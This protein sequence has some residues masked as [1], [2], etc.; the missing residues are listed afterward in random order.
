MTEG[1]IRS[2]FL[3]L[4][5]SMTTQAQA[6]NTQVKASTLASRLRDFTRMNSHMFFGSKVDKHP[7]DFL[8]EVYTIL[9]AMGRVLV[10]RKS[11][12]AINSEM[13]PKLCSHNGSIIG[14]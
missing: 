7:L 9:F 3:S 11:M 5:Q 8:D 12:L 10:R 6:V 14:L 13:Y 4:S 2:D 1:E